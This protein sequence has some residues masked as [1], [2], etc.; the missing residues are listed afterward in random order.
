MQKV[1]LLDLSPAE[2]RAFLAGL[3][4]PPYRA[5]QIQDWLYRRGADSF[6]QM[7]NLPQDLRG[8]LPEVAGI[9]LLQVLSEQ[10]AQDGTRKLLFALADGN[11]VETV[12]LP[13]EHGFSVCVSTQVGC[14]WKCG[15]CASG[16]QGF[17]RN[18]RPA[19]IM[20]QVLQVKNNLQSAGMALKSIVLM[21][22]GEPLD[23]WD[24]TV[25]FLRAVR[26]PKLLAVSLR[27]VTLST[28][29]LPE[30]IRALADFCWPVTLA[31]SLHAAEDALRDRIMPVNRKYP[32]PV[33]LAACDYY[34]EK[35]GRRITYEYI[36][37]DNIND[38][39]EHARKLSVLLRGRLCHVNLIALNTVRVLDCRPSDEAAVRRFADILVR[40]KINTTVRR[41]LGSEIAAACGQLRNT[42]LA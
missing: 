36:M 25:A 1:N 13:Y 42:F 40:E 41:R 16:L 18:L 32:L 28:V 24:G 27:H 7:T 39:Q 21:G 38:S 17:V 31:V 26:D 12:V 35:T 34:A 11:S 3:G 10:A 20:A 2:L 37:L 4:E 29:G 14:R 15:F 19:E 6:V 5:D 30:R 9:G 8:K 22:T 23:N 33:L